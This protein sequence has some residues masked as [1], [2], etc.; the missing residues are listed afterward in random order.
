MR[1]VRFPFV[2]VLVVPIPTEISSCRFQPSLDR[3]M[4]VCVRREDTTSTE[5]CPV[6]NIADGQS[7]AFVVRSGA[8]R[9]SKRT[10]AN[11]HFRVSPSTSQ[12][13]LRVGEISSSHHPNATTLALN[14]FS[15]A[16]ILAEKPCPVVF[17]L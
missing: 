5:V 17:E 15:K 12:T 3:V 4:E 2:N 14:R 9:E 10:H 7:P 13:T 1:F 16:L 8:R 6:M 11:F